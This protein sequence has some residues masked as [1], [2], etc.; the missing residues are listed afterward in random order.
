[1]VRFVVGLRTLSGSMDI[2]CLC[3]DLWIDLW[4]F[5][6]W[7]CL[8]DLVHGFASW[9]FGVD[10]YF[11]QI[12]NPARFFTQPWT[13]AGHVSSATLRGEKLVLP[14]VS[15]K[16]YWKPPRVDVFFFL[17]AFWTRTTGSCTT[18]MWTNLVKLG[19]IQEN[20]ARLKG[21]F[22]LAGWIVC[23]GFSWQVVWN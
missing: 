15:I 13:W 8:S 12:S 22:L 6:G 19:M 4:V 3:F 18:S 9:P 20:Q 17:H 1:M 2:F 10:A 5:M 23:P 7:Y 11:D 21:Q 14:L 16:N